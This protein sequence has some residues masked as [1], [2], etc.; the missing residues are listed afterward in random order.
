MKKL[1]FAALVVLILMITMVE[2]ASA[3][4]GPHGGYIGAM[5]ECSWRH[6]VN[7]SRESL[8]EN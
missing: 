4:G 8:V 2:I 6:R 7:T 1:P 3:D 5:D